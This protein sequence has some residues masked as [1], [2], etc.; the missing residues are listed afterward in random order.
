[1]TK[2]THDP[3]INKDQPIGMY[4]CPECGQMV[5]AGMP[6]IDYE[7]DIDESYKE[8]LMERSHMNIWYAPNAHMEVYSD[9]DKFICEINAGL[10]GETFLSVGYSCP[11]Y[12]QI[13]DWS[14]EK[15]AQIAKALDEYWNAEERRKDLDDMLPIMLKMC[16]L[17]NK[18]Y[19]DLL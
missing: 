13:F 18:V 9:N 8:Y 12:A 19:N 16:E 6:H 4:H 14:E 1:M 2:C 15:K 17:A 7:F 11:N 3:T 5:M 10:G